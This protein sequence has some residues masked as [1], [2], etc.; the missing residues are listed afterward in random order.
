MF[1][2]IDELFDRIKPSL[3]NADL[4]QI[5]RGPASVQKEKEV[6]ISAPA[7]VLPVEY[8]DNYSQQLPQS[9][10]L[11]DNSNRAIL[12]RYRN[13]NELNENANDAA[14]RQA[15]YQGQLDSLNKD[16]AKP[17][18]QYQRSDNMEKR[19]KDAQYT[20]EK[21][22]ERD[23]LSE[24]IISFGPAAFGL[25]GG[26]AGALSAAKAAPGIRDTYEKQR[27][28]KSESIT[29]RNKAAQEKY[30]HILKADK[31]AADLWL[32]QQKLT[33]DQKKQIID[34]VQFG[35]S[36]AQKDANQAQ[37]LAAGAMKDADNLTA[38]TSEK[39]AE[40]ETIPMKEAGKQRRAN[41]M[42]S[43]QAFKD[44]TSLRKEFNDDPIIKNYKS[45]RE[46]N[47][48]IQSSS[49]NPIGHL[50]AITGYAKIIDPGNAVK[51]GEFK[52]VEQARAFFTRASENGIPVPSFILGAINQLQGN[53][54]LL[55]EQLKQLKHEANVLHNSQQ[56]LAAEK[57]SEYMGYARE[58]G[59]RP[60][61][62]VSK[63]SQPAQDKPVK[64][65]NDEAA[66]NWL[67]NNPNSPDAEGVRKA[68]KA[69][70]LL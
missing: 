65:K 58:Y 60:N 32:A 49:D 27:K 47:D 69:K 16:F 51:E 14:G 7:Q 45:I 30:E 55:P 39:L 29:A 11:K 38:N 2:Q 62:V 56:K 31:E 50:S 34:N 63:P 70:G 10:I 57:E 67:K 8:P 20:P 33:Q 59:T 9:A 44:A 46:A 23:L 22:P 48:K 3:S 61:L 19:L 42:A 4:E 68:L 24:A 17:L 5:A 53:G 25:F 37:N 35:I 21:M 28:E 12:N 52:N 54:K 18:P 66:L 6:S 64:T 1:E 26:E 13:A 15:A 43:G 36:T 41:T 40:L